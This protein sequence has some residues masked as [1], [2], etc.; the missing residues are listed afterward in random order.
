M[1]LPKVLIVI[2][3]LIIIVG[4]LLYISPQLFN[5]IGKLP[6]DIKIEKD[7]S[8]IYL[9]ISTMIVMSIILNVLFNLV[10]WIFSRFK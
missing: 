10:G 9:P 1:D 5:W 4:I 6:G 8:R 7:N 3:F 2:G